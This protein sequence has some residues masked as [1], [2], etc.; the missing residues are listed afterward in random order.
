M[1]NRLL[2][3]LVVS[4]L[5]ITGVVVWKLLDRPVARVT[6]QGDLTELEQSVIRARLNDSALR[7]ILST[8]LSELLGELTELQ[9]VRDI[10][11]R[12]VWPDTVQVA[13]HRQAPVAAW[14]RDAYVSAS[15]ALLPLPDQHVDVPAFHVSLAT[16]QQT[17]RV[18]RLVEQLAQR[19]GLSLAELHQDQQGEWRAVM[20]Q[21]GLSIFLGSQQISERMIRF[22]EVYAKELKHSVRP[23]RYV[24]LRYASGAAVKFDDETQES[25]SGEEI[26]V[27]GVE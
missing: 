20:S 10:S 9:W 1:I 4:G 16:P 24:D 19:E 18:Y 13:L 26:L 5:L 12:R 11:V 2:T 6:I 7:G 8:N 25:G 3:L 23:V 22:L 15:G 14:G 21:S 27:A 17:M